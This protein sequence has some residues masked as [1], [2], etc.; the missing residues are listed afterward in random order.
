MIIDVSKHNG[1]ID[2]K[3]AKEAGVEG[4]ILRAGYGRVL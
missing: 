3:K 4:A 2:W 1:K